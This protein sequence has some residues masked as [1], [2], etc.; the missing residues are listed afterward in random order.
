[1]I[2]IQ[3]PSGRASATT[4]RY[5]KDRLQQT[6]QAIVAAASRRFRQ[7]G[8][9][10]VGGASPLKST[11]LTHGGFYKHFP[12]KESLVEEAGTAAFE[13]TLPQLQ[14][15]VLGHPPGKRLKALAAAYVSEL[16]RDEP[17]AGC[18]GAALVS[19]VARQASPVRAAVDRQLD[20][21]LAMIARF[22]EA[23][24]CRIAPR[25]FLAMMIG[26]VAL[27]RV[28]TDAASSRAY[29]KDALSTLHRMIDALRDPERAEQRG[30]PH[31]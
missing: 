13:E 18:F 5:P 29:L 4:M 3:S 15:Y 24:R 6:R 19:E 17:E 12:S 9:H 1:M 20:A 30:A 28:P 2:L 16:H 23:D 7:E 10:A 22:A 31:R 8:I 25:A 14:A 11:G 26:A 27:S 21:F